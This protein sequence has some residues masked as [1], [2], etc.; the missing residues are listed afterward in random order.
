[1]SFKFSAFGQDGIGQLAIDEPTIVSGRGFDIFA[2]VESIPGTV[3]WRKKENRLSLVLHLGGKIDAIET[4][5]D[6]RTVRLDPPTAGE[7]WLIPGGSEYE[8]RA[9]GESAGYI[10][11]SLDET[12]FDEYE[13]DLVPIAGDYDRHLIKKIGALSRTLADDADTATLN[14]ESAIAS[15]VEHLAER[16]TAK[17]KPSSWRNIQFSINDM[18]RLDELIQTSLAEQLSLERLCSVT[19]DEPHRFLW[20]FRNAYGSTPAQYII[21]MRLRKARHLLS[22]SDKDITSIA[23]ETGFSDHSHLTS[24]FKQRL[25]ITPTEFRIRY[26]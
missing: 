20:A 25:G 16:F 18:R 26:C 22:H 7:I 11:I 19:G 4:R 10:D 8:T 1:M 12:L 13:A 14:R 23:M 5:F 24:T 3:E 6:G 21:E 17:P 2:A 15:I 9:V